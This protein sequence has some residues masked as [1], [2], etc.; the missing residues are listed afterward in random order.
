M[1]EE[2]DERN[3]NVHVSKSDEPNS[4]AQLVIQRKNDD[5][6]HGHN[7]SRRLSRHITKHKAIGLAIELLSKCDVPE[8]LLQQLE[9]L[10][11]AASTH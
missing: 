1:E 5:G 11:A 3:F 6:S 10:K 8:E 7:P 9:S 2:A 4:V